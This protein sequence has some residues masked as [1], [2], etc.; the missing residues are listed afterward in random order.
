MTLF[1]MGKQYVDFDNTL[2]SAKKTRAAR[3]RATFKNSLDQQLQNLSLAMET[4]TKN[5]EVV[6]SFAEGNREALIQD[7]GKY[8]E[9]LK[10]QYDIDQFQFHTP[11]ATSFLRLHKPE[12]F[13]DDLSAFR[14]M[15]VEA[16]QNKKNVVGLEVGVGG[17]GLRVVFPVSYEDKHVGTVEFGGSISGLLNNLK[18]TFGIDYAIG[19]RP[20]VFKKAQRP[21]KKETDILADNLVFYAT[22]SELA[23][24]IVSSYSAG[25]DEYKLNGK[26]FITY[27]LVL[28]D[29]QGQ[30]IGYIL[31]MD[32]VQ[33]IVDDLQKKLIANLGINFLIAAIILAVL[34]FFIR[35]AFLPINDAIVTF[36][37]IAGGD[38]T[39]EIK[40][41]KKD[42]VAQM[43]V[44]IKNMVANLRKTARMAEQIALGDLDVQV[45]ILSDKDVLGKSLANMVEN[46]RRTAANAELIAKG[47]LRVDVK[48]LSAKDTLGKS[49]SAMIEKIRQIITD[50]RAAADQVASGSQEL[51]SSSEQVS[52][53]ASEQAAAVEEISSSMEELAGTVA[54]TADHARETASIA[55]KTAADAVAGGKAVAETVA[56]MQH[57]AEKIE[58]IE[59]IARQT[60]LLA[61]NAAIE[62]ARA[63]E[64]GK[65]FAVVASEVRKLAERSQVSAQEIKGVASSSVGTATNAGK[66]INE[67]VPQI[68][69]TAELVHEIDAASNEQARGI[70]ENA[71]AIQ[72]FDQ[73]IQSNSAAAEEMASTSE[74]LTAQAAQMQETIAF[75]KTDTAGGKA[76]ARRQGRSL[77]TPSPA[78]KKNVAPSARGVKLAL[79]SG[80]EED[81]ERY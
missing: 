21:E 63:G 55:T 38:L 34:F 7:L 33:D 8:N 48:L 32:D 71:R 80:K 16:N 68:Q 40:V 23:K 50:V 1:N 20:D 56:A 17:P 15:V 73:V 2:A 13:G 24:N 37:R 3:V 4:L 47:D 11:P 74:E 67:I 79:A 52:Q 81:F 41:E 36:D 66:L 61:L 18:E 75:F 76:M 62:A 9:K 30:E 49:L 12:K 10:K 43:L 54:Q 5:K 57:I 69:K 45:E 51:S 28:T 65:G 44:A 60:N 42:E 78:A 77:P 64:H 59:E 58:L 46:L 72:Q 6:R 70:D 39:V 31:V 25:K 35:K 27:P 26:F 29:Y 14:S 19:I 22:S 53:G